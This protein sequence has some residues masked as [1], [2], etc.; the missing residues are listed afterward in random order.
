MDL[1]DVECFKCHKKG[2]YASKCPDAKSKDDK[3]VFKV[4]QLEEPAPFPSILDQAVN[5]LIGPVHDELHP[6]YLAYVFVD[7]S[8]NRNKVF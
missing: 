8:A 7:T 1:K 4:R 2:H 5:D 3:G 6:G